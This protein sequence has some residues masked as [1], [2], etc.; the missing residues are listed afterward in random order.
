ME[1]QHHERGRS[2]SARSP[3]SKS[4]SL[5]S[6]SPTS[7][8]E[9]IRAASNRRASLDITKTGSLRRSL[10]N[11]GYGCDDLIDDAE[12]PSQ[13]P[14]TVPMPDEKD[15]YE[16]TWDGDL[17]PSN[18]RNMPKWKKWTIIA[19]TS[20]G[21]FCV[22]NA[23]AVYTATYIQMNEEFGSSRL[24]ATIGLSTFVLGIALGPFWSP[25]AEFYG[26]RP[27]YLAAF[28]VFMIFL[29]PSAVAQNIQTMIVVRFFQG[30]AGSAFLSV[31]GGTV[32]DL[33]IRDEMQAPMAIFTTAPFL[34][35]T[36]GPL[37]GGLTNSYVSWRWT[38]YIILIESAVVIAALYL[39]VPETYRKCPFF[40]VEST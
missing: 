19:I 37:I 31:S 34:G 17:D 30:L 25:L 29:I 18:P 39:F 20:F 1:T 16:V 7:R 33:F 5:S 26:R 21:S 15:P 4:P 13:T 6:S 8:F 12:S 24:V 35:P 11:N 22:T 38:H 3:S 23:S 10:S 40:A 32:G 28:T 9:P 14:D 36:T 2:P 27:I